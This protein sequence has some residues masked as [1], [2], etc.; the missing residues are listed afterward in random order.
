LNYKNSQFQP[1]YCRPS[2]FLSFSPC[3]RGLHWSMSPSPLS[4]L[5]LF[6]LHPTHSTHS[7]PHFLPLIQFLLILF[8]VADSRIYASTALGWW[9]LL[10]P[11]FSMRLGM[12]SPT[13]G[14]IAFRFHPGGI[15]VAISCL[16]IE[17]CLEIICH[18][19]FVCLILLNALYLNSQGA[20]SRESLACSLTTLDSNSVIEGNGTSPLSTRRRL[21]WP[22]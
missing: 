12:H 1:G 15:G 13:L 20:L 9:L 4:P 21:S 8:I 10:L 11:A 7:S 18:C 22:F 2:T 16:G 6:T 14:L 3:F 5:T 19:F 17:L